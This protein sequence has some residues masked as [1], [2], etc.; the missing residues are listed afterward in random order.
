M[1]MVI[2]LRK[3]QKNI[4]A[5]SHVEVGTGCA[6]C[7]LVH[8]EARCVSVQKVSGGDFHCCGVEE[9][10]GSDP[11]T[12]P[13][14]V[15]TTTQSEAWLVHFSIT[16]REPVVKPQLMVCDVPALPAVPPLPV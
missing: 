10:A 3:T 2:P 5:A 14:T 16:K 13:L 7:K 12:K 4:R 15:S 8:N 6:T 1:Y 9:S 11:A